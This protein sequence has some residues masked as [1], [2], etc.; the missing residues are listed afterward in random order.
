MI[1]FLTLGL[2]SISLIGCSK[3]KFFYQNASDLIEWRVGNYFDQTN[4]DKKDDQDFCVL[5]AFDG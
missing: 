5:V 1:K 3:F 2:L 4:E